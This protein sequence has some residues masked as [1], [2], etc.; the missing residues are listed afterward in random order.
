[1]KKIIRHYLQF[2]NVRFI[3]KKNL[4]CIV[5]R[6]KKSYY[7]HSYKKNLN[8]IEEKKSYYHTF[9]ILAFIQKKTSFAK[10]EEKK[11]RVSFKWFTFSQSFTQMFS[12]S[13]SSLR[14]SFDQ[15]RLVQIPMQL[16]SPTNEQLTNA[17]SCFKYE[18]EVL[19]QIRTRSHHVLTFSVNLDPM[20]V[21][22]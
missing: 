5:L 6:K 16:M 13:S 9:L 11:A 8:C 14:N 18:R 2:K 4:N 22:I 10:N 7:S 19:F 21:K 20:P 1:M 12:S 3:S 17:M 15:F